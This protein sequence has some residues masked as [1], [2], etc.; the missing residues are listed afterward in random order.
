[1]ST[2]RPR[3][4]LAD[5]FPDLLAATERLLALDCEVVGSVE[6]GGILLDAA[7]RLQ[8]DV[9][10]VDLNIPTISG[11]E[12][13]RQIARTH[14]QIKVILLTAERDP[15][16]MRAALR[17]GACAFIEKQAIVET[18]LPAI[19]RACPALPA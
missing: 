3:V 9:V 13:C 15:A 17:A 4:L 14:P 10:V 16:I 18:L 19:K 12:A 5:D 1:M 7:A 6:D 11:L 2:R 8:P